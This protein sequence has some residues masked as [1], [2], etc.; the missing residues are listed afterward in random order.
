M[1]RRAW[2]ALLVAAVA[3]AV[4]LSPVASSLPDGLEWIA[5]HLGFANRE[6]P[7]AV[8]APMPDYAVPAPGLPEPVKT[9]LAGLLGVLL[10]FAAAWGL[11]RLLKRG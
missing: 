5:E 9:A 1:S 6:A 2:I 3:V 10:T 11:A 8:A 7:A 4:L